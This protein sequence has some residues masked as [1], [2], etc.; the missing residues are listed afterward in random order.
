MYTSRY[1]I[2][3]KY[4]LNEPNSFSKTCGDCIVVV[5]VVGSKSNLP[6]YNN[7]SF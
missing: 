6:N 5:V 7:D 2:S 4:P 1:A 3:T